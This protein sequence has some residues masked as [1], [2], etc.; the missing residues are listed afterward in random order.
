MLPGPWFARTTAGKPA[1]VAEKAEERPMTDAIELLRR[2]HDEVDA[3][4]GWTGR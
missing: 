2:D 4:A 3:L 1:E